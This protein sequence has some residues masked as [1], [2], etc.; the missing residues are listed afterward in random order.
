MDSEWQLICAS[1][2]MRHGVYIYI[3]NDGGDLNS[4]SN[5]MLKTLGKRC[6]TGHMS[7]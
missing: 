2:R 7:H 4:K 3:Y 5:D 6:V 1:M